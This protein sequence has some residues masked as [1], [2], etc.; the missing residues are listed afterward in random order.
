MALESWVSHE[1][2]RATE[3]KRELEREEEKTLFI[4]EEQ[5]N[6]MIVIS[7]HNLIANDRK[8]SP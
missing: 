8:L 1:E 2:F 3:M 4:K 5:S 6:S 7:T